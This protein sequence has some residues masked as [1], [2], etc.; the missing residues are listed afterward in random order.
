MKKMSE[1]GGS[2][3]MPRGLGDCFEPGKLHVEDNVTWDLRVI[4]W[5]SFCLQQRC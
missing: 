3:G 2:H 5:I 1:K 4:C